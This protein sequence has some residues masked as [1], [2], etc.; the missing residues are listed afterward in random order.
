M[1]TYDAENLL[2]DIKGILTSN[3]NTKIAAIEAEKI[4]AGFVSTNLAPVDTMKGYFEQSWSDAMLNINPA[5][6]YGIEE[7]TAEG[8]GPATKELYKIFVE[9]VLVD[10]GMDTLTK[11]RIHRYARAIK[12][13]FQENY[14]RLPPAGK[15]KIE[16]VR[17]TS[18]KLD[19]NSSEE[20]KVGGVSLTVAIA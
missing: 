4:G 11:N 19:L 14:D 16:T 17:P 12:E 20:V 6:F 3:L 13:V 1:T 9:I 5:I 18:F 8:Q 7:T 15:I 2:F 10:N